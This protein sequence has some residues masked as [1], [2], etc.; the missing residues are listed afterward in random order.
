MK[1]IIP[2]AKGFT[3]LDE[4]SYEPGWNKWNFLPVYLLNY[5]THVFTGGAVV[6]WSRWFYENRDKLRWAKFMD[7]LLNKF[8]AHHGENAG[9]ALW[10]TVA[11]STRTRLGLF[12]LALYIGYAYLFLKGT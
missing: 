3:R 2:W 4:I 9:G 10:G 11:A 1:N 6:S 8:E 5:G 7:R 12:F